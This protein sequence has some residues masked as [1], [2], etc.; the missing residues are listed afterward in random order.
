MTSTSNRSRP[1]QN[2]EDSILDASSYLSLSASDSNASSMSRIHLLIE[3]ISAFP[4]AMVSL[5][6]LMFCGRVEPT[7]SC[8][9][10]T[11]DRLRKRGAEENEAIDEAFDDAATAIGYC[12]VTV[13]L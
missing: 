2:S 1:T 9:L 12:H 5:N 4:R 6:V 10:R 13:P 3:P 8:A 7:G 11:G